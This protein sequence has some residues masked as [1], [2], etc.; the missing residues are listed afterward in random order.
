MGKKRKT[1]Q[2]KII[3]QLKRQL[4]QQQTSFSL[5]NTKLEISQEEVLPQPQK[6]VQES[7]TVKISDISNL[8]G[9][10][11]LIKKDLLKTFLLTLLIISLE[12]VLYLKLR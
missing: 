3:L 1:R 10:L 6:Q 5:P 8:S 4:S 7:T 9:N 12:T 11:R 2:E